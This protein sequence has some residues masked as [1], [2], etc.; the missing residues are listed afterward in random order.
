MYLHVKYTVAVVR[1]FQSKFF[2]EIDT[3]AYTKLGLWLM[4]LQ[5]LR[6]QI[7]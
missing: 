4:T 3:G 5:R 1:T 2:S 7:F 6:V